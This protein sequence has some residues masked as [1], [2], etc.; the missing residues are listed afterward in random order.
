M[1]IDAARLKELVGGPLAE[2]LIHVATNR[3]A[4]QVDCLGKWLLNWAKM[5]EDAEVQKA[6]QEVAEAAYQERQAQLKLQ[7]G[8]KAATDAML[9]IEQSRRDDLTTFLESSTDL[10]EMQKKVIAQLNVDLG[11]ACYMCC[12][13]HAACV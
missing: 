12:V 7:D 8:Q 4:D 2:G 11:A 5:Q 1:P 10:D 3:P 9:A 13:W 6:K